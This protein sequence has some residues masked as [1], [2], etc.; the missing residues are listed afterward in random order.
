MA[1]RVTRV[2]ISIAL[3]RKHPAFL[4]D[5]W[6]KGAYLDLRIFLALQETPGIA[7]MSLAELIRGVGVPAKHIHK[8]LLGGLLSGAEAG[9]VAPACIY[10]PRN[11]RGEPVVLIPAQPGP[12]YYSEHTVRENHARDRLVA[13][14]MIRRAGLQLGAESM[15][16]RLQLGDVASI[17]GAKNG[18]RSQVEECARFS[19]RK[20]RARGRP[21]SGFPSLTLSPLPNPPSIPSESSDGAAAERDEGILEPNQQPPAGRKRR[22]RVLS[23]GQQETRVEFSDWWKSAAWPRHHGGEE[24]GFEPVDGVAVLRLLRHPKIKWDI[25]RARLVSEFYLGQSELYGLQG[26]PLIKLA[27]RVNY[28]FGKMALRAQEGTGHVLAKYV[29]PSA[30]QRGEYA[31][32]LPSGI[33]PLPAIDHGRGGKAVAG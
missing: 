26:H 10:T 27:S 18:D 1:K 21:P 4:A 25:H 7:E 16:A 13:G 30:E 29:K 14:A 32:D 12:L 23:D 28:Y 19:A 33:R 31:S 3:V 9:A 24:Y 22:P 8:L 20:I 6:I 5:P 15:R 17:I 2:D 11:R